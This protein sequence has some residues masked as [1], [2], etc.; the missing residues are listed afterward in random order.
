MRKDEAA[1]VCIQRHFRGY[2]GRKEYLQLLYE[3]FEKVYMWAI[4]IYHM[5]AIYS[6]LRIVY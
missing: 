6:V 1:A 4:Y 3:Q 5:Q 2:M